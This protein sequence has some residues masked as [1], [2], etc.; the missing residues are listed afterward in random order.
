MDF[1]NASPFPDRES[2]P[3]AV[4]N[5]KVEGPLA[6]GR[7]L[8]P[9]ALAAITVL[10][11][12]LCIWL[13]IPYLP[14]LSWAFALAIIAWPLHVW[15]GRHVGNRHLTAVLSTLAVVVV[16]LVPGLVVSYQL[17]QEATS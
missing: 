11:I 12:A 6:S 14:A 13:A 15:I 17:A 2:I 5:P 8:R 16:I 9:V 1:G 3:A 7:P 4:P 10:L